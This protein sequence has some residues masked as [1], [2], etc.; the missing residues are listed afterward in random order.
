M[1]LAAATV[2]AA[3][4]RH[5]SEREREGGKEGGRERERERE[6]ERERE[7]A[8]DFVCY[9]SSHSAMFVFSILGPASII[10]YNSR[11][12]TALTN[13]VTCHADPSIE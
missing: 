12:R 6:I 13:G 1:A 11:K 2:E 5:R 10:P 3:E 8:G 7:S 9:G 4:K